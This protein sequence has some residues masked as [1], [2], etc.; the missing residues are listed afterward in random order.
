[1]VYLPV[2]R[3]HVGDRAEFR[4]NGGSFAEMIGS[5]DRRPFLPF[6]VLAYHSSR[7]DEGTRMGEK[8]IDAGR[9]RF[10]EG[11]A[12]SAVAAAAAG[13][14]T[15]AASSSGAADEARRTSSNQA[16]AAGRAELAAPEPL[17]RLTADFSGSDFMVDAIKQLDIEYIASVPA[18][19]FRGLQESLTHY[20]GN[21]S[22][23]WL[24][25]LHEATS[26]GIA[27]GYARASFNKPMAAIMK[28]VV[29]VQNA[30]MQI[31]NTYADQVPAILFSSIELDGADRRYWVHAAQDN[32]AIVRDFTK[33]DDTPAS[34]QHFAES[35]M[36]AYAIATTPPMAPVI[37]SVDR[38]LQ[39]MP[40]DDP[41]R[42]RIPKLTPVQFPVAD[43][44]AIRELARSLVKAQFPVIVAD[45]YAR[46]EAGMSLL[47]ELAELLG[48][49]VID[50]L[51]RFNFP[52]DHSL[53]QSFSARANL[54]ETDLLLAIEPMDLWGVVNDRIE[55]L[56]TRERPLIQDGARIVILGLETPL[57]ANYQ[58]FWRY[59]G[60][61]EQIEGEA[62][63]SLPG[64]IEE[65]RRLL[66]PGDRRR[67]ADR[68]KLLEQRY[69]D[70]LKRDREQA[71]YAW[72]A[73]PV[74]TA[75]LSMEIFNAIQDEDWVLSCLTSTTNF[76]S[77]RLWPMNRPYRCCGS[78]GAVGLGDGMARAIGAGLV[79]R[80]QGR[81][82]V[83][84]QRDGD[85]MFTPGA[86]WTAAHHEVP[87]LT[88][89]HNNRAYHQE[90]MELQVIAN[91][92]DR[93]VE[94]E[95]I[96]CVI[97]RPA[98]DFAKLA[99]SMGVWAEGPITDPDAL[100]PALKRAVAVVRS[101]K[102][103]LVDVVCEPR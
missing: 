32:N 81:I 75:R 50:R 3:V 31:Y 39:E 18:E 85:L 8:D 46:T 62:E 29:G 6:P 37:L 9:R 11:A 99:E 30:A 36:R 34:L 95:R 20:G 13:S 72:N 64:L 90:V 57:R 52:T 101:G 10:I 48:A 93:N 25:C 91:R 21:R 51:Q 38:G 73:S 89:M 98:I 69:A 26:V 83:N 28:S 74:S 71:A 19:S 4:D 12:A 103:A 24:T 42:L 84:I 87:V 15:L 88:V 102:P 67:F 96:G 86:L 77:H 100:G 65:V 49:A 55:G 22:P 45:R 68:R 76:W 40:L 41:S 63:A 59:V 79:H 78:Y 17:P 43:H 44:G 27:L 66:T 92:R 60:A 14:G 70:R 82:V 33:W 54:A 61:D 94:G 80:K 97:D 1:M 16:A 53:N 23:E 56:V 2:H 5:A 7:V 35:L 47:V 58:D